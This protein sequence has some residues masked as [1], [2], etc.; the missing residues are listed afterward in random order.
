MSCEVSEHLTL[1][2]FDRF[3]VVLMDEWAAECLGDEVRVARFT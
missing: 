1:H 2:L 3:V